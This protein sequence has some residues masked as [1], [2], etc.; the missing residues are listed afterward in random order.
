MSK[1]QKELNE[2]VERMIAEYLKGFNI[3]LAVTA[4][5]LRNPPGL[6]ESE[7]ITFAKK[8]I[9]AAAGHIDKEEIAKHANSIDD[10]INFALDNR[11]LQ[12]A[13]DIARGFEAEPETVMRILRFMKRWTK[14]QDLMEVK[15]SFIPLI[16]QILENNGKPEKAINF[17]VAWCLEIAYIEYAI[18]LG[19]LRKEPGLTEEELEALLAEYLSDGDIIG[20]KTVS[21]LLGRELLIK[22]INQLTQSAKLI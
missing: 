20:S 8:L 5:S 14:G 18:K 1:H 4:S 3:E 19:D 12:A 17:A 22:E 15:S 7:K 6:S 11:L 2:A 13:I 9:S 10:L 21:I 16:H